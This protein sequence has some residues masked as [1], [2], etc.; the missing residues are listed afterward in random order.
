ME[1]F[2]YDYETGGRDPRRDRPVQ[3]S[4]V[5]TSESLEI[6]EEPL[7]LMCAPALDY[8]PSPG[9]C[10][11]HGITPQRQ[12]QDGL[13]EADFAAK[14]CQELTRPNTCTVGYNGMRFDHEVTRFLFYRN[15]RDPYAWHWRDGNSRWDVIDLMR[16]AY[17]LRFDGIEWA[18]HE[19]GK[20]SFK[21]SDLAKANGL[22]HGRAHDAHDDVM[23]MLGLARLVREKHRRLFDDYLTLRDKRIVTQRVNRSFLWF[24]S[25][26][27]SQGRYAALMSPLYVDKTG[28]VIAVD[29]AADPSVLRDLSVD[30]LEQNIY[31]RS[32]AEDRA[33][34]Y[35]KRPNTPNLSL[36][37]I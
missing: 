12:Q 1:F 15:L 33:H 3:F 34:L 10:L 21:L 9:A 26:M 23:M 31:P 6:I 14:I 25:K 18:K 8:L 32:R 7:N 13:L 17:A 36:I 37:H 22:D 11:V 27:A 16:A 19:E 30:E 2:W 29:L 28:Q 20:P 24:T 5:R 4:G 35:R